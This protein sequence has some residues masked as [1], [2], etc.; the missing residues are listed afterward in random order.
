MNYL[1]HAYLSFGDAEVL[2]GNMISDYVKGKKKFD[3]PLAIQKGIM[4]H[5][6]IDTFTDTHP[7]TKA[8]IVFFKPVVGTYAGAFVDVVYDHFLAKDETEFPGETLSIFASD[9][10]KKLSEYYDLLPERFQRMLPHMINQNWLL[11]YRTMNGIENSFA[12]IFRRAKY[13]EYTKEAFQQFEKYYS[14]LQDYYTTF[15]ADVKNMA[16]QEYKLLKT[17]L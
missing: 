1:A 4:L 3:Y 9:A 7:A 17:E 2:V 13:I 5:R 12:G 16:L 11:N 6:T 14:K 15:F 8:A 10:Y